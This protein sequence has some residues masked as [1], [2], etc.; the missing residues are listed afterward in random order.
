VARPLRALAPF[1]D[2]SRT[3]RD[4]LGW[5]PVEEREAFLDQAVRV[6]GGEDVILEGLPS[7]RKESIPLSG[8]RSAN[9]LLRASTVRS[10][11][12]RWRSCASSS[13]RDARRDLEV[14]GPRLDPRY[15]VEPKPSSAT[16]SSAG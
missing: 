5:K 3:A 16:R 13:V 15:F 4:L 10:T 9:R 12:L 11:P 7:D 8:M 6:H 2:P 1:A 14:L